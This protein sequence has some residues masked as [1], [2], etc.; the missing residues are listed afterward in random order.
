LIRAST[1]WAAADRLA[2]GAGAAGADVAGLAL[3]EA[4]L[5]DGVCRAGRGLAR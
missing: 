1:C 4:G 3:G 2:D 5:G